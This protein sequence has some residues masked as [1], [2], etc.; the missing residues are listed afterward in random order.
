MN[1]NQRIDLEKYNLPAR[2]RRVSLKGG[3]DRKN[4]PR[5]NVKPHRVSSGRDIVKQKESLSLRSAL[6]TAKFE[7]RQIVIRMQE[8]ERTSICMRICTIK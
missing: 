6:G 1:E 5:I 2:Y 8:G 3:S 4:E 7:A